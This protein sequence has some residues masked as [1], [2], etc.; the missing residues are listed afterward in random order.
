[1]EQNRRHKR[2]LRL[3]SKIAGTIFGAILGITA[4]SGITQGVDQVK[5]TSAHSQAEQRADFWRV[6][7]SEKP[8]SS[9]SVDQTLAT[10]LSRRL[11]P[12]EASA[13]ALPQE[14][15][16]FEA[17][18]NRYGSIEKH[19]G[20]DPFDNSGKSCVECGPLNSYMKSKL[21]QIK[22]GNVNQV[23]NTELIDTE[24]DAIQLTPFGLPNLVWFGFVYLGGGMVALVLAIRKDAREN[25]Y[26]QQELNW[27]NTGGTRADHYKRLSK[28]IS[29]L[30]FY[31][32]LPL[33]HRQGK[34][35]DEALRQTGLY[36]D[37]QEL[38][39]FL[40][41][42]KQ[43][44]AGERDQVIDELS[45]LLDKIHAQ[46]RN[47]VG[48][49]L[50]FVENDAERLRKQIATALPRIS[51][52]LDMRESAHRELDQIDKLPDLNEIE[53]RH[54]TEQTSIERGGFT[55]KP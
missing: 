49:E 26:R 27:S 6:V 47:Y 18:A 34:D 29:P 55:T 28:L 16:D 9:T 2:L 46:V 43:L 15:N 52:N 33:R 8:A 7:A 30:Y 14:I 23:I 20:F 38:Q 19:L 3:Q 53:A 21:L 37:Y 40:A 50:V 41:D 42:T 17:G 35:Y 25:G 10:E 4:I 45:Q 5:Q 32:V 24:S 22:Q 31:T 54:Q 13:T 48:D 11:G 44:P 1:M 36:A 39:G 51:E 12:P